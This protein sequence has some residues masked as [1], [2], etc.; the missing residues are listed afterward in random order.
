MICATLALT[1]AFIFLPPRLNVD[2]WWWAPTERGFP[3]IVSIRNTSPAPYAPPTGYDTTV[4][5]YS[6]GCHGRWPWVYI[7]AHP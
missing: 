5:V 7:W 3:P 4:R 1:T 2:V 6:G